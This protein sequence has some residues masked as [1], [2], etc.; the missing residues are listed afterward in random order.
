MSHKELN[1]ETVE[2]IFD[3]VKDTPER[4]IDSATTLDTK[5][6][7]VFGT[8]GI[9]IALLSFSSS[10][11]SQEWWITICLVGSLIFYIATALVAFVHLQPKLFKRSLH[12]DTLWANTWDLSK[13]QIHHTL[14]ADVADA[15]RHNKPILARKSQTL[16]IAIVT[17][18]VEVALVGAALLLSRVA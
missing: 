16:S 15:Y 5:M 13:T 11:W 10:K 8:A 4:Q 3:L 18:S 6:V 17:T 12:G 9:V 1:P 2:V 7:Q 14:I